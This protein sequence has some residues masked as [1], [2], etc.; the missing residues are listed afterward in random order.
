M[1]TPEKS[2]EQLITDKHTAA[3]HRGFHVWPERGPATMPALGGYRW[4]ADLILS[5]WIQAETGK[6]PDSG[7]EYRTG[8]SGGGFDLLDFKFLPRE[9]WVPE[10]T[11]V[12]TAIALNRRPVDRRIEIPL[13][14]YGGGMSYGSVS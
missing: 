9:Q 6:V 11:P 5:T 12:R 8:N 2:I 7:L 10:A 4:T 1:K 13:P 14:L 3:L